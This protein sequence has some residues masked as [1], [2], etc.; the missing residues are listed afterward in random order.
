M[1]ELPKVTAFE[2]EPQAQGALEKLIR[3][4]ER[5]Y[6]WSEARFHWVVADWGDRWLVQGILGES[7]PGRHLR[8]IIDMD[9]SQITF[10]QMWF[11]W[12]EYPLG[13]I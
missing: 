7:G 11:E 9:D 2:I 10:G 5:H 6:D 13:R 12:G 4:T 8:W 3:L 1:P